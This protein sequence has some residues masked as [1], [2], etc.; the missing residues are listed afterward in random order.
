M[1]AILVTGALRVSNPE[2]GSAM[3]VRENLRRGFFGL[4]FPLGVEASRSG[5]FVSPEVMSALPLALILLL[6]TRSACFV[7]G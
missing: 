7:A 4:I 6:S 5:F 2:G 1:H 3:G